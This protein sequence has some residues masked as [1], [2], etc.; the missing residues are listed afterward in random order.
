MNEWKN[1][2]EKLEVG[3]LLNPR[4]KAPSF[5]Q[6]AYNTYRR[7]LAFIANALGIEQ[8]TYIP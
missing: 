6:N 3:G 2:S 7:D 8:W 1:P 4:L 5:I